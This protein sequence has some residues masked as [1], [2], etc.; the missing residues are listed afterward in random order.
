MM[1]DPFSRAIDQYCEAHTA[2]AD[3]VLYELERETYL[4]TLAPQMLSGRLQGAFL[5]LIS[6]L[7][8]PKAILEIGT[9]TGYGSICLARG[10]AD[11]GQLH[12]LEANRE[13]EH[14]IR[15]YI[16]KAGLAEKIRLHLGNALEIIPTLSGPFDLV[17]I[18]AGK[19]D[20]SAYF[21]L[22]IGR[23]RPGGLMLA[24]NV[25]WSGKVLEPEQDEDTRALHAFNQKITTDPRVE[26]LILPLRDGLMMARKR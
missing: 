2:P 4:K 19:Q 17:F 24:D 15:K 21:D 1:N 12:T 26:N 11:D 9:F 10:L 20:Y 7:I 13:L 16:T 14:I 23:I 5:S 6:R 25:L 8:H 22:I 18:D 3:S